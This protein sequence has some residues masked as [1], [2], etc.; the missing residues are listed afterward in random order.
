[1]HLIQIVLRD[2]FSCIVA[3]VSVFF[4]EIYV[5]RV[6]TLTVNEVIQACHDEGLGPLR[7]AK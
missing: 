3:D 5:R 1:V 6:L 7:A 2:I 4:M